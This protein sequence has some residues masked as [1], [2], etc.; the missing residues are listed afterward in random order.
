[1]PVQLAHALLDQH[2]LRDKSVKHVELESTL[3]LG[4]GQPE[5]RLG[6]VEVLH[7]GYH[8]PLHFQLRKLYELLLHFL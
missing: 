3:E 4:I 7:V 5:K 1:M 6:I 2:I 8:G